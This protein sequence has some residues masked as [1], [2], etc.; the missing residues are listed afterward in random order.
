M[1][2]R[3][4]S[5]SRVS[6]SVGIQNKFSIL[7]LPVK[8]AVLFKTQATVTHATISLVV[9][10]IVM[11]TRTRADRLKYDLHSYAAR[12]RT[13]FTAYA[14]QHDE[15]Q[16]QPHMCPVYIFGYFAPLAMR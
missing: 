8:N 16:A 3:G 13:R 1:V 5:R 12:W 4:A 15:M 10:Y 11:M 6:C 2:T 9:V 14:L 7:I